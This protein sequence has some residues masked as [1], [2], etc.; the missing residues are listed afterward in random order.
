METETGNL[1]KKE[2]KAILNTLPVDLTFV[3]KNDV[4]RYFNKTD[5]RIFVR[6]MDDVGRKMQLCHPEGSVNRVN[7]VLEAF[8][9]GEKDVAEFWVQMDDHQIHIRFFPVRDKEGRYLGTLEVDQDIT[10]L[11]KIEGEKRRLDWLTY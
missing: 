11:K 7:K 10:D 6:T 3:D 5:R 2:A 4:V 8:K 1:S 9:K